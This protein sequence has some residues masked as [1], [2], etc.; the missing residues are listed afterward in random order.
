MLTERLRRLPKLVINLCVEAKDVVTAFENSTTGAVNAVSI[1]FACNLRTAEAACLPAPLHAASPTPAPMHN[2][3]RNTQISSCVWY[4]A[5][6]VDEGDIKRRGAMTESSQPK[7]ASVH[8]RPTKFTPQ[9]IRQII[10]L[11]DRGTPPAQIAEIIGVTLGT[12]RVTCSKLHI[13]LRRPSY[14]TGTGLLRHRHPR[15]GTNGAAEGSLSRRSLGGVAPNEPAPAKERQPMEQEPTLVP[16]DAPTNQMTTFEIVMQYKGVRHTVEL[17][18][19]ADMIGRLALEAEF[20]GVKSVDLIARVIESV[21]TADQF[22]MVLGPP[23]K[24]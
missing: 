8:H 21:A 11:V 6:L 14:H 1:I 15:A 24:V 16:K 23:A 18:I 2:E 22:D 10:N 20:R 3:R 5:S 7:N 9:N 17:P 12:L 4:L 13:S 19:T